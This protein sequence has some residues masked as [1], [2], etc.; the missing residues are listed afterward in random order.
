MRIHQGFRLQHPDAS[1]NWLGA[2]YSSSAAETCMVLEKRAS[3]NIKR[4]E[5]SDVSE[6][7]SRDFGRKKDRLAPIKSIGEKAG[8]STIR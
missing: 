4:W 7:M 2:A 5:V 6:V 1:A 8:H 3:M